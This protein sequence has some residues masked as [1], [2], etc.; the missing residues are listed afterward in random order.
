MTKA[1]VL[2]LENTV[3]FREDNRID[4]SP[5][6]E[7]NRIVSAHWMIMED[8]QLRDVKHAVF[9]HKEK[10]VPDD[11][12]PLQ[13]A[14]NQADVLVAQNAKHDIS[15]L[16]ESGFS[17]PDTIYDTMIGEYVLARGQRTEFSLEEI[18]KR[19]NVTLKKSELVEQLFK[20]KVGYE[21][22]PLDI[23]LEYGDGDV[24][25]C[26]EIYLQQLAQYREP[27]N[28]GLIPTRDMSMEMC[29]FL[30]EIERNG[31]KIDQQELERVR[32]EY[33]AERI[34]LEAKLEQMV[35]DVMGDRPINLAS[36][37]DLSMVVYSRA[38]KDRAR[39]IETFNLGTQ[40][41]GKKKYQKRMSPGQFRAAVQA[42]FETVYRTVA[43]HCDTCRGKG[44]IIKTK[45]DG[46]AYAKPHQCKACSGTGYVQIKSD[47][48]AGFKLMPEGPQDASVHGFA[49]N[50]DTIDRLIAQAER[51]GNL[52]AV[53]FL[54]AKARLAAISTYLNSFVEGI[55]RNLR[56]D[57]LLHAHFNQCVT[58]TGRLSSSEPNFQ[59]QP[60]ERTFPIRR[61][62]VSRFANGKIVEADYSALEFRVAGE[63]SQDQQI[64]DDVLNG[65]DI[66]KQTASI[67]YQKPPDQI[68]KDERQNSKSFTFSPLY[69]G[70]GANEPEHIRAYFGKFF[71]IYT[72]MKVAQDAWKQ[73][74]LDT[75]IVRIPSG[76]EFAFPNVRRTKN[77]V[78]NST[79]ISNYPVQSF[80]TADIVPIACIS[81]LRLFR[82][83]GLKSKIILTVHDS[84]AIDAHP[85][86]ID[87][88]ASLL[89]Q[90]MLSV[91]D[92]LRRRYGY[93]M[94]MPLAIEVSAGVNWME[95]ELMQ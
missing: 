48:I 50:S 16:L 68:T 91:P 2:D 76:R 72:G 38:L 81:L 8:E 75:G 56:R 29:L 92:E 74:A 84:I 30:V 33:E 42:N 44:Y 24:Q 27:M 90:A 19:R 55:R 58:R 39:H 61:T 28:S 31:I 51:K 22:M 12:V 40:A 87:Q 18:A 32:I 82:Q 5:Y 14:L 7:A 11:F 79:E 80:A 46:S 66:H 57:G 88:A 25:T 94:K 41:N 63:L 86:E 4:G 47:K 52:D 93:E 54:K 95:L 70:Q 17:I 62:V 59:N 83:H 26:A 36:G 71:E 3:V 9:Y 20:D 13:V 45:K 60:K 78:T 10:L 6:N 15:W 49:V 67:I 43:Y 37:K 34:E 35:R 21:S 77:G 65:K 53:V 89:R 85:D 64:F 23:V 73:S 1:I 69:G